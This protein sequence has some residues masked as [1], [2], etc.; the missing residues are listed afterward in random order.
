[1]T[2]VDLSI[3]GYVCSN[4]ITQSWISCVKCHVSV[5]DEVHLIKV[6]AGPHIHGAIHLTEYLHC[7]RCSYLGEFTVEQEDASSWRKFHTVLAYQRAFQLFLNIWSSDIDCA[8]DVA[9]VVLIWEATV[10]DDNL[11]SFRDLHRSSE[12]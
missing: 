10:N 2:A 9:T 6:D 4:R 12:Q 8:T 1:M 5:V 7:A 11:S 3:H